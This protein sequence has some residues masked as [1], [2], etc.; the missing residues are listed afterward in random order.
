MITTSV[1]LYFLVVLSLSSRK[2]GIDLL[3]NSIDFGSFDEVVVDR[4]RQ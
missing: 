3:R 2:P 1:C 4:I